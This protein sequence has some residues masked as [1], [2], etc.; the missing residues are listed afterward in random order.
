[1]GNWFTRRRGEATGRVI[2]QSFTAPDGQHVFMLGAENLED[3]AQVS[4]E[5]FT[6]VKQLVDL[7]DIDLVGASMH[8]IGTVMGASSAPSIWTPDPAELWRYS[9]D[10][11][12][13]DAVVADEVAGVYPLAKGLNSCN[14]AFENFSYSGSAARGLDHGAALPTGYEGVNTPTMWLGSLNSYTLQVLLKVNSSEVLLSAD[15][16][17]I[18]WGILQ[19]GGAGNR[20]GLRVML[21][22]YVVPGENQYYLSVVHGNGA[23]ANEWFSVFIEDE[24]WHLYTLQCEYPNLRIYK[25]LDLFPWGAT[26]IG[27]DAYQAPA[28]DV[29]VGKAAWHYSG[30]NPYLPSVVPYHWDCMR[31]LPGS[32]AGLYDDT[33]RLNSYDELKAATA[34]TNYKWVMRIL[35]GGI[36]Y[37]TR[38]IMPTEQ[39]LWTDFLAPCRLLTG[40]R[41]VAFRLS[42]ESV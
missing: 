16:S 17:A 5:D 6:E 22:G 13:M 30:L 40:I 23:I 36:P 35:I 31:L 21:N 2:P 1:M 14:L 24:E 42:L 32:W 25:D 20:H 19:D 11:L 34:I 26:V 10:E 38:I 29:T 4:P 33:W 41:E 28:E 7:T 3:V 9:F 12:D 8:T 15:R 37:A 27:T 39:R 18:V